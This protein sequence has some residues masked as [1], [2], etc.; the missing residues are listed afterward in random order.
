MCIYKSCIRSLPTYAHPITQPHPRFIQK[1]QKVQNAYLRRAFGL[2]KKYLNV[3]FLQA[4][5]GIV[6]YE[7]YLDIITLRWWEHFILA[8]HSPLLRHLFH[9]RK[10]QQQQLKSSVKHST[11]SCFRVALFK[12]NLQYNWQSTSA[13][14]PPQTNITTWK[15]YTVQL[16]IEQWKKDVVNKAISRNIKH[17]SYI[18][19][20]PTPPSLPYYLR[21]AT[22]VG[23]GLRILLRYKINNLI[24]NTTTCTICNN[25]PLNL[26]Y[27]I[28][29]KCE[30]TK[31]FRKS[32]FQNIMP[33]YYH[34]IN[35]NS[36]SIYD[37]IIN[38]RSKK[39]KTTIS[40]VIPTKIFL[41]T[42]FTSPDIPMTLFLSQINKFFYDV[43]NFYL[44]KIPSPNSI[45]ISN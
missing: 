15:D 14:F 1:Q 8:T 21:H 42:S 4:E 12:Y 23:E 22:H 38:P 29:F 27:H 19:K 28:F 44:S 30:Q 36:S 5:L 45:H 10:G 33:I 34:N 40:I 41:S 31:C 24:R 26:S 17:F 11:M 7:L 32:F 37:V 18:D 39:S 20:I 16:V 35:L 43:W 25:N 2:D 6:P 13:T 9:L 3:T